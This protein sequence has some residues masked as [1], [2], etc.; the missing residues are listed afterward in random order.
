[1]RPGAE[2]AGVR[3]VMRSQ[4]VVCNTDSLAVGSDSEARNRKI[5]RRTYGILRQD[6]PTVAREG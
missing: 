6:T 2:T 5:E 3:C 1:M 4:P